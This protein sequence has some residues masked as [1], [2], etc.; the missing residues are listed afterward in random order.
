MRRTGALIL[1]ATLSLQ[2]AFGAVDMANPALVK[3]A[4][5]QLA[6]KN[7]NTKA[8]LTSLA[9]D[10]KNRPE[11]K[12]LNK[13][14][15]AKKPELKKPAAKK[16]E[17]KNLNKKPELKA[18][19]PKAMPKLKNMEHFLGSGHSGSGPSNPQGLSTTDGWSVSE[20]VVATFG[21]FVALVGGTAIWK[22]VSKKK[23]KNTTYT[24]GGQEDD[25]DETAGLLPDTINF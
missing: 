5:P 13:K 22:Y 20:I 2:Q 23:K 14:P 25:D 24:A 8:L 4:K 21:G 3:H 6:A 18:K 19:A 12:N 1:F 15:A 9:S 17:L 16:P 7:P 11:L 10:F